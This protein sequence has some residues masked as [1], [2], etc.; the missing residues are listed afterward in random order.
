MTRSNLLEV[1]GN[2]KLVEKGVYSVHSISNN[3]QHEEITL[4]GQIKAPED[5][6]LLKIV[7][8]HHSIPVMDFE[9][10]RFLDFIPM[11]GIILD[12]GGGW[13]WHW[14]RLGLLRPDLSVVIVDFDIGSFEVAK[15]FLSA[16]LGNRVVLVHADA[17]SLPF[18]LT[19]D[20]CG[21]DGVWSVQTIQHIPDFKR[22]IREIFRV[23]KR[24]GY[25]ATYSLSSQPHIRM[26][27]KFLGMT[28]TDFGMIE[29][30][31]WMARAS[32]SQKQQIG[33]IFNQ[34]VTERYSEIIF[35]PELRCCFPGREGSILGELD[36]RMSN[37]KGL[38]G[39]FARQRS[40]HC[41]KN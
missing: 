15:R 38:L 28:Y 7:S 21:F 6:N 8:G 26:L 10:K 29:G 18:T 13:G 23:M 9:L 11:H 16:S 35:S 33:E 2:L 24:G 17:L 31:Y 36:A 22:A 41:K 19:E 34:E 1:I 3:S 14:R 40:F 20:F 37:E 27:K 25:F 32:E 12:I 5:T 39:W 30:H 4:R